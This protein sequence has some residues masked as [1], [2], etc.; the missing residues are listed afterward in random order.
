MRVSAEER[1]SPE[2]VY[3]WRSTERRCGPVPVIALKQ[4]VEILHCILYWSKTHRRL[5]ERFL[6]RRNRTKRAHFPGS[7]LFQATC[8]KKPEKQTMNSTYLV[9]V[10]CGR[11][12]AS[13]IQ[14]TQNKLKSLFV[15]LFCCCCT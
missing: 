3:R 10:G 14:L 4:S 11:R 9:S 12:T 7:P 1:R 8:N 2:G 13:Y 15:F 6:I 5:K